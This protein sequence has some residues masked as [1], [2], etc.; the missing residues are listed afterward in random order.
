MT[1][2]ADVNSNSSSITVSINKLI[3]RMLLLLLLSG[4]QNEILS[5]VGLE[6]I[7][8]ILQ[9]DLTHPVR[10]LVKKYSGEATK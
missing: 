1:S 6:A 9:H 3:N 5:L 10:H 4:N 7:K 2:W 8:D